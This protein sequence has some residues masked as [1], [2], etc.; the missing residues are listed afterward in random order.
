M[1]KINASRN[2]QA[3]GHA[4]AE[5]EGKARVRKVS[6]Q[7]ILSAIETA[8][9]RLDQWGVAHYRR[10]GCRLDILPERVANCYGYP[11]NGTRVS[12]ERGKNDWFVTHVARTFTGSISGG[13][14]GRVRLTLSEQARLRPEAIN[15]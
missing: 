1:Q 12:L 4:I 10:Q 5:A 7:D 3:V 11:A 9:K 2:V 13:D 8:E 6:T 14:S 15:L